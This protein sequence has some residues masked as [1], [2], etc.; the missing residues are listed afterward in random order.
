MDIK[1]VKKLVIELEN[2]LEELKSELY[3]DP[4]SYTK[5]SSVGKDMSYSDYDDDGDPD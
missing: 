2:A 4:S 5:R 1:K 3:S